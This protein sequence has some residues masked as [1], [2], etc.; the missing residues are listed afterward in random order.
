MS[1]PPK[2]TT[3]RNWECLAYFLTFSATWSASS[4]VG[5]STRARTGWRA[6]DMLAF[7]CRNI[8]CS[9]GR[10]KAAVF[11]VPVWAAPMM[12]RPANTRGMALAWIGVMAV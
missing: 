10:V 4:R 9:N 3:E 5:A 2:T 7:S 11:P 1:T 6:G 8:F 12:S